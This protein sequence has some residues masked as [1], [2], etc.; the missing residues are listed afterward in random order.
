VIVA[1]LASLGCL[2]AGRQGH[3]SLEGLPVVQIIIDQAGPLDRRT[4]FVEIGQ[5]P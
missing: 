5:L 3:R 2:D 1:I 4:G